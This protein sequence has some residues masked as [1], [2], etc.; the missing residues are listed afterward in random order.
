VR[1]SIG[2]EDYRDLLR[3]FQDALDAV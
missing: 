2:V 3:D 1:I